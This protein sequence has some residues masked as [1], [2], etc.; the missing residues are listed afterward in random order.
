MTPHF[1]PKRFAHFLAVL[2]LVILASPV[3]AAIRTAGTNEDFSSISKAV[4][5]LLQ[6]RDVARFA[7]NLS[8]TAEDWQLML[9]T[10]TAS[11][12][13]DTLAAYRRNANLTRENVKQGAQQ[14]LAKADSL[15][16]NFSNATLHAQVVAPLDFGA[17]Y[18]SGGTELPSAEKIEINLT[19]VAGT[20]DLAAGDFKLTVLSMLKYPGGWRSTTGIR[21]SSF[22]SNIVDAKTIREMAI[23]E[24]AA[25]YRG[26]TN[27]DDP[28]LFKLGD[29]L[30][31]FIRARDL[32]VFTNEVYV[33]ADL[34]WS[35][36]QERER[37]APSRK[38]LDEFLASE[39]PGQL[40]L[41]SSTVQLMKDAG[42]DL[43]TADIQVK[44]VSV[45]R[46]QSQTSASVLGLIGSGFKLRFTVKTDAKAKSGTSLS[47]DYVL[48]AHMITRFAD[49]W[50]IQDNVYWSKVPAG[51]LSAEATRKMEY[52]SY[53]A[54]HETLP[55]QTIAPE[56]EFI[57]LVDEKKMKLSDLRG[58][59][60]VLDFWATWCGPC[61]EPMADLQT[62]RN[63]HP[64]WQDKVVLL[65][66]S[67]DDTI[68]E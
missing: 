57:T 30:I 65:P 53:V 9:S 54:E 43:N 50:R 37:T 51:I 67:I 24:K 47:G 22:P 39:A 63:T 1:R 15:H 12:D 5:E 4:V 19:S 31:H 29:S 62:I 42:I 38:D 25:S 46:M 45:G 16:V 44:E 59:V 17:I 55:P 3:S 11:V 20:N 10:N 68:K 36:Y 21:W 48:G 23:M 26:M 35:T 56:I 7:T 60:V 64:D 40:G 6:T 61:Q 58:K 28:A 41:A 13:A 2:F 8:P 18:Y 33:T 49:E 27:Q 34:I 52:E 66:L 32:D 14:L